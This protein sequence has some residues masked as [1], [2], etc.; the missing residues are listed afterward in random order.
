MGVIINEFEMIVEEPVETTPEQPGGEN[1]R[2]TSQ[3]QA[4]MDIWAI[5][6]HEQDRQ[7][8]VFAH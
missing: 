8:R 5:V 3:E 7:S 1:D 4:P 2:D 6:L